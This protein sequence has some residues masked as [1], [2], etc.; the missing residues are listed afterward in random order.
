MKVAYTPVVSA[1]IEAVLPIEG[2][3]S[4]PDWAREEHPQ[5]ARWP[6]GLRSMVM[7]QFTESL[8]HDEL[9]RLRKD[10]GDYWIGYDRKCESDCWDVS[11]RL[12]KE[13]ASRA[14]LLEWTKAHKVKL[15][16]DCEKA[17]ELVGDEISTKVTYK[18]TK[19]EVALKL[20][21]FRKG[22][23]TPHCRVQ[24]TVYNTVVC[25]LH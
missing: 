11:F 14:E 25:D 16:K 4:Q 1:L 6:Q 5:I 22:A 23:P 13:F 24:A 20:S 10:L 7:E 21:Y 18:V 3:E 12:S 17:G 19:D 8:I 2:L 9:T 15:P